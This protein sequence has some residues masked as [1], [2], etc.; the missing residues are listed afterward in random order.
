MST[1]AQASLNFALGLG[2]TADLNGCSI[3]RV[4]ESHR[5]QDITLSVDFP[6][7]ERVADLHTNLTRQHGAML[8]K[9][10]TIANECAECDYGDGATGRFL[11]TAE[12]GSVDWA[13]CDFCGPI[14]RLVKECGGK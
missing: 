11:A 6:T 3:V 1:D 9:L 5:W 4:P 13:E 2:F 7:F 8:E 14:R 12:D 10:A